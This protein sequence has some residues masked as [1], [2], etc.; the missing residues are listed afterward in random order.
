MR[1][2]G[3]LRLCCVFLDAFARIL[4]DLGWNLVLLLCGGGL[5]MLSFCL[6][7]GWVVLFLGLCSCFLRGLGVLVF[8]GWGLCCAYAGA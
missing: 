7:V 8:F 1:F 2:T 6:V 3:S 5:F 4:F